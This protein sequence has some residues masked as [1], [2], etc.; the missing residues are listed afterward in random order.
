MFIALCSYAQ[1]P[2]R[3]KDRTF[4][5]L[6]DSL[7]FK[8]SKLD[9]VASKIGLD[10]IKDTIIQSHMNFGGVYN[11][12][13]INK[14]ARFGFLYFTQKLPIEYMRQDI[15]DHFKNDIVGDTASIC[16]ITIYSTG[17]KKV[18]G[19][20]YQFIYNA[21]LQECNGVGNSDSIQEYY[22]LPEKNREEMLKRNWI[23]MGLGIRYMRKDNPFMSSNL[24][25]EECYTG[26]NALYLGAM[27]IGPI[28][29][30]RTRDKIIWGAIGLVG[31]LEFRLIVGN[32]LKK[33]YLKYECIR[34]SR[35]GIPNEIK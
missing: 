19:K 7:L 2:F 8:I 33:E 11:K 21:Y 1:N 31:T 12:R 15:K 6:S 26:I 14:K 24:F 18:L 34:N 3:L 28:A 29:A 30:K 23:D 13:Y 5:N 22:K 25:L 9:S 17:S 4:L 27:I 16:G 35:Y 32:E 10:E 20:E